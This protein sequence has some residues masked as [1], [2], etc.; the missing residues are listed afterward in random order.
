[1]LFYFSKNS[2]LCGILI[3]WVV[4]ILNHHSALSV[5]VPSS[6]L[7]MSKKNNAPLNKPPIYDRPQL[8]KDSIE[9]N[10][11]IYYFGLGSNMLR[12]KLENR[13]MNGTKIDI[14]TMEAAIVPNYRLAFNLRGFP[15]IEPGMG[16]LEPVDA[17]SQALLKYEKDECHGALIKLSP[18]NYEKVM[19]SE[20]VG[21]TA[22]R[23]TEQGY[24]EIVVD[25]YPY[26]GMK[27]VK[28]IALRAR[29]HV[30]LRYDPCPSARYMNIL[31][32]GAK[33][34]DLELSYQEFLSRHPVQTLTTWQ[35]K[36]A[37]YNIVFVFTISFILKW[38]GLSKFQNR[39]LFLVYARPST[40]LIIRVASHLITAT[41]LLPGATIGCLMLFAWKIT[42][43][44]PPQ[45]TRMMMLLEERTRPSSSK[46][47]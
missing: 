11:P 10:T 34:L 22:T 27:S 30:R 16:S 35:R 44:T 32:E 4:G 1:M 40:P 41:I 28:A 17:N 15:P 18:E 20:G 25:A 12:E 42:G 14:L 2:T 46:S 43:T 37:I 23:S 13:G 38:R 6:L 19:R 39:L 21:N 26:R 36:E 3:V 47:E 9:N 24:E 7:S 5:K 31:K 33:E 8:V 29:P 45:I